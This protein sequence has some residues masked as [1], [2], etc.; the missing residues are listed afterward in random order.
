M[1]DIS[2]MTTPTPTAMQPYQHGID[3]TDGTAEIIAVE[4]ILNGS[5]Q[6]HPWHKPDDGADDNLVDIVS[7]STQHKQHTAKRYKALAERLVKI[8]RG[9]A[10]R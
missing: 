9:C 4:E 6:S 5:G 3:H 7:Q 8:W 1:I 10:W 2:R